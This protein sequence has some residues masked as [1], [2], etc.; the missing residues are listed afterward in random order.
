MNYTEN[1]INI[2]TILTYKGIGRGWVVKNLKGNESIEDIVTLLNNY[3]KSENKINIDS[4]EARKKDVLNSL[5]ILRDYCDG[6]VALGDDNFPKHRGMVKDSERPVILFYKGDISLLNP[7]NINITVIGLL[8]PDISIKKREEEIVSR[9]VKSGANIIS[10]LAYGCDSIAHR[11]A[12][13]NG[14]TIAI[15]PSPLHNILPVKNKE[16]AYQIVD[17][18]GLLIT[19]YYQDF[20]SLTELNNRYR[21]RDRLQALF[22]DAVVLIASYAKDSARRWKIY[23]KKLDSGARLAME[24]A[25]SYGI[26]RAVMYEHDLDANNP[27]FDLNRQLINEDKEIIVI[28]RGNLDS[29]INKILSNRIKFEDSITYQLNLFSS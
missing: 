27:M 3:L 17:M 2:L 20:K 21:E 1:A 13:V 7:Q 18:G 11:Q 6:I 23:N 10:G 5:N 22:C 8:T 4:F 29:V 19:E 14:K 15:L 26:P 9:L 16:L 25:K 28:G 24:F 12:L